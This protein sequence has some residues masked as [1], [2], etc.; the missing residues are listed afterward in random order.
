MFLLLLLNNDTRKL[1]FLVLFFS[2]LCIQQCSF[3]LQKGN[4]RKR[5]FGTYFQGWAGK[6]QPSKEHFYWCCRL[7]MTLESHSFSL[8]FFL[9]CVFSNVL[10]TC[11]KAMLEKGT[12]KCIFKTLQDPLKNVFGVVI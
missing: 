8:S 11:K 4:F 2:S 12:S 1:F 5:H 6:A 3:Y 10:F 7:I 9:V